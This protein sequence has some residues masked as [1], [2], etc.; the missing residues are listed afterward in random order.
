MDTE[1]TASIQPSPRSGPHPFIVLLK[2]FWPFGEDFKD[3]GIAG[4][5]YEI[6]KVSLHCTF[7]V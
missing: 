5:I 6:V 1:S 4:K 2:A 3:L 7:S